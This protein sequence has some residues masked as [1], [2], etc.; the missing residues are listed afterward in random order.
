MCCA[1]NDMSI[2]QPVVSLYCLS[3]C[4]WDPL[5]FVIQEKRAK[6]KSKEARPSSAEIAERAGISKLDS[7][8][9][10]S[11]EMRDSIESAELSNASASNV[12]IVC[13]VRPEEDMELSAAGEDSTTTVVLEGPLQVYKKENEE[14]MA[15]SKEPKRKSK[16]KKSK[17]KG[18]KVHLFR[19]GFTLPSAEEQEDDSDSGVVGMAHGDWSGQVLSS[20]TSELLAEFPFIYDQPL[21]AGGS[22]VLTNPK[23]TVF[24][25]LAVLKERSLLVDPEHQESIRSPHM[26]IENVHP[27]ADH[28]EI[29]DFLTQGG[30]VVHLELFRDYHI[31]T[32]SMGSWEEAITARV[33]TNDISVRGMKLKCAYF[34]KQQLPPDIF[35][36]VAEEYLLAHEFERATMQ[37]DEISHNHGSMR[38]GSPLPAPAV[39][40]AINSQ[41]AST[42][43]CQPTQSQAS[44][45]AASPTPII[46]SMTLPM[47]LA[48][49]VPHAVSPKLHGTNLL[50]VSTIE[51]VSKSPVTTI[52][53]GSDSS[54]GQLTESSEVLKG[55]SMKSFGT[56]LRV[57]AKPFVIGESSMHSLRRTEDSSIITA[58]TFAAGSISAGLSKMD[59]ATAS[60]ATYPA[61]ISIGNSSITSS[62]LTSSSRPGTPLVDTRSFMHVS[63]GA[64]SSVKADENRIPHY[65][66]IHNYQ[67]P[68][69]PDFHQPPFPQNNNSHIYYSNNI[70]EPNW[71]LTQTESASG[72]PPLEYGTPSL[73]PSPYPVQEYS[74]PSS[75]FGQV[76]GCND[77]TL[78]MY[79]QMR[80]FCV[81][82]KHLLAVPHIAPGTCMLFLYNIMTQQTF[83]VYQSTSCGMQQMMGPTMQSMLAY[84]P[85]VGFETLHDFS[86]PLTGTELE[87]V[88]PGATQMSGRS[89][90]L[91]FSQVNQV[92]SILR[93]KNKAQTLSM[94]FGIPRTKFDTELQKT[95]S[96]DRVSAPANLNLTTSSLD[97][98]VPPSPLSISSDG[99]FPGNES[100][101]PKAST[102]GSELGLELENRVEE[103]IPRLVKERPQLSP[104]ELF[105]HLFPKAIVADQQEKTHDT[106]SKPVERDPLDPQFRSLSVYKPLVKNPPLQ[107]PTPVPELVSQFLL[108][109]PKQAY[110]PLAFQQ[111]REKQQVEGE[112]GDK[113][114]PFK[115]STSSDLS[116]S[117]D[118]FLGVATGSS[119]SLTR[120]QEAVDMEVS[121]TSTVPTG[122]LHFPCLYEV[123]SP[124]EEH[125]VREGPQETAKEIGLFQRGAIVE[126]SSQHENWLRVKFSPHSEAWT[127]AYDMHKTYLR[128]RDM[129]NHVATS[130]S[131]VM[132]TSSSAFSASSKLEDHFN[133]IPT[134]SIM[135]NE[136]E[137]AQK[138][139]A[140]LCCYCYARPPD[141]LILDCRHLGPCLD[142][143]NTK[144]VDICRQ[145][146][147]GVRVTKML[148]I[149][150]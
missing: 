112:M 60:N 147:C 22:S 52:P 55:P 6:R 102:V 62:S 45:P 11:F 80:R 19:D 23:S 13:D 128:R 94:D 81:S 111:D 1:P 117:Q 20:L 138:K 135:I 21:S 144:P 132:A 127:M 54:S 8:S 44:G 149:H 53:R 66:T 76:I 137:P 141:H 95:T 59:S 116:V 106:A 29:K 43:S 107:H 134:E 79:K 73:S 139:H 38:P 61:S 26:L 4:S 140:H 92:L 150:L 123:V 37:H 110:N 9:S 86:I 145:P 64:V 31:A 93:L 50:Q 90:Y 10:E 15:V 88:F 126:A 47:V 68:P 91:S 34:L 84:A 108:P 133:T 14:V 74:K 105:P 115:S 109:R 72:F 122:S 136:A 104:M 130:I 58:G 103:T 7:S 57:T 71:M 63:D 32:V 142:C 17:S 70:N 2:Q 113:E 75:L 51:P 3:I 12:A 56:T 129:V 100:W 114:L 35:Y 30:T 77:E 65:S 98:A 24:T 99:N 125:R 25:P 101:S 33:L 121:S 82:T 41:P 89:L 148:R 85:S 39:K 96:E 146:N 42:L 83:G 143:K 48:P 49:S 119:E 67:F 69:S 87:S 78:A 40:C 97:F 36:N 120:I 27:Q 5:Q 46:N 28:A 118:R 16:V 131:D 124:K 18:K